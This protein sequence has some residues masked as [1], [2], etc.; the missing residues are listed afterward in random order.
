MS[1]QPTHWELA[2]ARAL[3]EA[4]QAIE[5][6]DGLALQD[7]RYAARANLLRTWKLTREHSS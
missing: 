1:A 3:A 6:A 7:P 2:L 4:Q 5:A